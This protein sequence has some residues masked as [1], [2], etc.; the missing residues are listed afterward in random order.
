[1]SQ[2][3]AVLS[4]IELETALQTLPH[5]EIADEKLHRVFRFET[6]VDAFGFMTR[7][8]LVAERKGSRSSPSH[9]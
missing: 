1:M 3:P 7:A 5:W 9:K 4:K 8:A 6:F 2:R